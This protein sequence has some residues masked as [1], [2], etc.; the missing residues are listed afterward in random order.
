MNE[1]IKAFFLGIGT[2]LSSIVL[3]FL[4]VL[5]HNRRKPVDD[6]RDRVEECQDRA[7]KQQSD[8]REQQS[9]N[10]AA[11][12]GIEDALEIVRTVREKQKITKNSSDSD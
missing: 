9:D 10:S 1:K 2:T 5:L 8:N 3:L 4:G 11:V 6:Y 7:G 12:S